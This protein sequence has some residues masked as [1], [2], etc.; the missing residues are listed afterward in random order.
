MSR[1][2]AAAATCME[3]HRV[4]SNREAKNR[5]PYGLDTVPG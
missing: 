1:N 5:Q 3:G 2:V 4:A